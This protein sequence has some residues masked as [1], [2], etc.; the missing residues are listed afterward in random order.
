[1]NSM[2]ISYVNKQGKKANTVYSL[3]K[4]KRIVC[5]FVSH[6]ELNILFVVNADEQ[7]SRLRF[8]NRFKEHT[9]RVFKR[10]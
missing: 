8:Y 1:M 9:A 10:N 6:H 3:I 4:R 2:I 5:V 7:T